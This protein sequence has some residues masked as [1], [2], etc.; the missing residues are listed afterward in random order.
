MKKGIFYH[1][2]GISGHRMINTGNKPLEVLTIYGKTA[3]HDYSFKSFK[4][5]V[6]R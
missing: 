2:P 1:V 6:M 4:K 5:R 3:G